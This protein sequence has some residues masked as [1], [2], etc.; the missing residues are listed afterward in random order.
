ML[1]EA[2]EHVV[3]RVGPQQPAR[4]ALARER[5]VEAAERL[6]PDEVAEDEHVERDLE[7]QLLLDLAAPSGAV[8]P[9]L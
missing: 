3:L 2:R 8:L 6:D 1:D 4:A 7:P 9:D 5:P